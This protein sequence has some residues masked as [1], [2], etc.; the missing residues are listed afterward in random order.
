[1]KQYKVKI[2]RSEVL[3]Y[4]GHRSKQFS[5]DDHADDPGGSIENDIDPDIA[6]QLSEAIDAVERYSIPKYTYKVFDIDRSGGRLVL[7][8]T[9]VS[10]TGH[11]A[12]RLLSDCSSCIVLAATVGLACDQ[13]I[14]KKQIT[15]MASALMLDCCA[16]SAIESICDQLNA[17][18]EKD[19][20][21]RGLFLT[22]RY[23]PGYG[24]MPL[25][26]QTDLCG[27][28]QTQKLIGLSVTPG[29]T[30]TPTKSVTAVIGISDHP[31]A[32]HSRTCEDCILRET[33]SYNK[34]GQTCGKR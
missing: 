11:D 27:L 17:D 3:R 18:L 13:L 5:D 32:V 21:S 2:S 23:S 15:D 1:M 10:L 22:E 6:L 19:Y 34:A 14:R 20:L 33:C 8:G 30:L 28:L 7:D 31:Q 29:L 9:S 4:M 26:L 16:S 12:D 25:S 24:D